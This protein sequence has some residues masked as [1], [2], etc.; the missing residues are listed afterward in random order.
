[1]ADCQKHFHCVAPADFKP[2]QAPTLGI[3]SLIF[4]IVAGASLSILLGVVS[5]AL[6][7]AA[8][9][10]LCRFLHGGK[11]VCLEEDVCVIGR[12]TKLIPVGSDK[13][14]LEKM[15]DDFTFEIVLSP[16]ANSEDLN[17]IIQTDQH[18]SKFITKQSSVLDPLG[19][20]YVG[21]GQSNPDIDEI[22]HCEVKGCRVHD[23]CIVLKVMSFPIAAALVVCSLPVLGWLACLLVLLAL[24][25]LTA[26]L[27]GIAWA[28]THNGDIND[29][30]D[31]SSGEMN[32]GDIVV[33]KG[34]WVYDAGHDGWNEIHPVRH[35]QVIRVPDRFKGDNPATEQLVEQFKKRVLDPWCFQ[36]SAAGSDHVKGE[37]EKPE[38]KWHIHP[39]IDGCEPAEAP[40]VIH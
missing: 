15:D 13:S 9:F 24:L 32:L 39:V 22:L 34:D 3:A 38:N 29:V 30:L 10:D 8:V 17:D 14:G 33:V 2:L 26:L 18:Q 36:V 4:A 23:V 20:G 40:P 35:V 7:I 16:H 28:A 1:M 11:L 31:P 25:A 21:V 37:Q 5:A 12:V 6:F 27:A 19:L